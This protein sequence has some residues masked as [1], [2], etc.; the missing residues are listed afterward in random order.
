VSDGP[1]V[2]SVIVPA[3]NSADTL[4]LQL[5]ALEA[6]DYEGA[7]EIVIADNGSTDATVEV[8]TRHLEQL[9]RG[10]VVHARD[11]RSASHAR[12]VGAARA[13]GDFLAFTDA[14][15]V[16]SEGWLSALA[17]AAPHGDLVAGSVSSTMSDVR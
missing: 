8:A 3:L 5:Q 17:R 15:D 13:E 14:D 10:R 6:Q 11:R 9:E 4:P 7:W 16:V 12:N 2:I 1:R